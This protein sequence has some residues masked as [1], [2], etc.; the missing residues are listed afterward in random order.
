MDFYLKWPAYLVT[1]MIKEQGIYNN[2]TRGVL[3]ELR[4][5]TRKVSVNG[6]SLSKEELMLLHFLFKWFRQRFGYGLI[7]D[8]FENAYNN[9]WLP[10]YINRETSKSVSPFTKPFILEAIKMA[11][12][13]RLLSN[14]S[15]VEIGSILKE[16]FSNSKMTNDNY[17]N[18]LYLYYCLFFF[19]ADLLMDQKYEHKI[20]RLIQ[21]IKLIINQGT[22]Y[23]IYEDTTKNVSIEDR[24]ALQRHFHC[25]NT[26]TLQENVHNL[27][28]E[29][30]PYEDLV[31]SYENWKKEKEAQPILLSRSLFYSLC[32]RLDKKDISTKRL[33]VSIIY[34]WYYGFVEGHYINTIFDG[35]HGAYGSEEKKLII[36]LFSLENDKDI[37]KYFSAQY[38][39]YCSERKIP[40]NEQISFL[41][42]THLQKKNASQVKMQENPQFAI[43]HR[44]SLPEDFDKEHIAYLVE[45]VHSRLKLI[46]PEFKPYL[47]YFLGG[48]GSAPTAEKLIQWEGN[49]GTLK[50][51][52]ST[53]YQKGTHIW[54]TVTNSFQVIS[55][56]EFISL[57]SNESLSSYS[58][59]KAEVDAGQ[60]MITK[61][62]EC[63]K[64]AKNASIKT[65]R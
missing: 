29:F 10:Q 7:T 16:F 3:K 20:I 61:I 63:I 53:L 64:E 42:P 14:I 25:Q 34:Y 13:N 36:R 32:I 31:L 38:G 19:N 58:K 9:G 30:F 57:T 4:K 35:L 56:N 28:H 37:L 23:K 47:T 44:L 27:Q 50:Y 40:E 6:G 62:D 5:S 12:Y 43:S 22:L 39:I 54:K 60:D 1:I 55:K 41:R 8:E 46:K 45:L 15:E 52:L 17:K 48:E 49:R 65:E 24:A 2:I 18:V 33:T 51:F 59:K 26:H 21:V 11:K